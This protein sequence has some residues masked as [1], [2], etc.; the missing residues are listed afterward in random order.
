MECLITGKL[1]GNCIQLLVGFKQTLGAEIN[2][3]GFL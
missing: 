3:I 1:A 2:R